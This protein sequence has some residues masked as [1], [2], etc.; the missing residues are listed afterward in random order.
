MY[1]GYVHINIRDAGWMI[2]MNLVLFLQF[3]FKIT[4]KKVSLSYISPKRRCGEKKEKNN[5]A[6]QRQWNNNLNLWK[7]KTVKL[8]FNPKKN[9]LQKWRQKY[10]L[11]KNLKLREFF[12][13]QSC[14]IK[15]VK[16]SFW[17][18]RKSFQME[19]HIH[20]REWKG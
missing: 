2:Y 15:N 4:P 3:F 17:G 20:L 9:I 7:E 6:N 10:F 5:N 18:W 11:D 19:A 12:C 13:Q 1:C 8:E 14:A 16:G